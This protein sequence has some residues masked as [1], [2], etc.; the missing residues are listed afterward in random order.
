MIE[1]ELLL[2]KAKDLKIEVA[3]ADITPTSTARFADTRARSP[4]ETEFRNAL[5]KRRSARRR[6]IAII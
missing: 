3:D 2:Q 5:P 1:E 6:S 4:T